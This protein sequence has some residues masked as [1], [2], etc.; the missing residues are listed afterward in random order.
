MAAA[1]CTIITIYMC[2]CVYPCYS[3]LAYH[4]K[5]SQEEELHVE[6]HLF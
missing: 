4:V 2:A 3:Y 1:G 5:G 6:G